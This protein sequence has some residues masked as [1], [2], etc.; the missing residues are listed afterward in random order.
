MTNTISEQHG[1]YVMELRP[2]KSEQTINGQTERIITAAQVTMYDISARL[3]LEWSQTM[4][5]KEAHAALILFR[6]I[7]YYKIA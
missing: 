2:I 7:G 5:I 6:G 1:H 4:P 3:P